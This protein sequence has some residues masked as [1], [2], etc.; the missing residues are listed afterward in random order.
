MN[1]R[2]I[3]SALLAV[4]WLASSVHAE[5]SLVYE[6]AAGPGKGSQV[7]VFDAAAGTVQPREVTVATADGNDLIIA[8]GLQPGE[9]VVAAGV[10]VLT[11]GQKVVRFNPA[12]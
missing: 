12:Q 1:I 8:S 7:W 6:G 10:H 11:P 9:E 3:T 2:T 4:L 5:P